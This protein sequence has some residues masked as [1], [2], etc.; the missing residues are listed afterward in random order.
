MEK[1][2]YFTGAG[3]SRATAEYIAQRLGR[4]AEDITVG[5]RE[6]DA[7][8][9]TVAVFPVYCESIPETVVQFLKTVKTGF[10]A[11]VAVY[12]GIRPGNALFE[13]Q[14]ILTR[15]LCAAIALPT[16]HSFLKEENGFDRE[17]LLPF[18]EKI[19][20][21]APVAVPPMRRSFYAD[22]LPEWRSRVGVKIMKSGK[23]SGCGVCE[24]NCPVGTMENGAPGD[25]C[26]RCLRC[27]TEC[28]EGALDF[29]CR[30]FLKRFLERKKKSE[31]FLF[32]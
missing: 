5:K 18:I 9:V 31:T 22:V 7:D 12:G 4:T 26:I 16:G 15:P 25:G 20:E 19:K 13:A 32:I 8:A 2:Y 10:A 29:E 23:C 3:H 11:I 30:P 24:E 28:P 14:G 6:A 17:A 1:V 27:V 21:P